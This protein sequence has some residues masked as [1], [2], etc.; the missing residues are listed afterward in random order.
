[1]R[2]PL[3]S[4]PLRF[5]LLIVLAC[6]SPSGKKPGTTPKDPKAEKTPTSTGSV[7][8]PMS[9]KAAEGTL[10]S[11]RQKLASANGGGSGAVL[12]AWLRAQGIAPTGSCAG[13]GP[14]MVL[15]ASTDEA[16]A[17]DT[18]AW[19]R[20]LLVLFRDPENP[21]CA[22]PNSP[23]AITV[24]TETDGR[25]RVTTRKCTRREHAVFACG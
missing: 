10:G 4:I 7:S 16:L 11:L 3:I 20:G 18:P 19:T 24:S 6:S 17:D 8:K 14:L 22:L 23:C 21:A 5:L 15:D 2:P 12:S 25:L 9:S 13:D 1:M